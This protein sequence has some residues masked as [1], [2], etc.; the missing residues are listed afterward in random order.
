M[1]ILRSPI[2]CK[3]FLLLGALLG[4]LSIT[5]QENYQFL[6]ILNVRLTERANL[7]PDSIR[8]FGMRPFEISRFSK[9][10][11][12]SFID[13]ASYYY[14]AEYKLKKDHLISIEEGDL[15]LYIDPL[16]YFAYTGDE[17]D[18]SVYSDTTRLTRNTRGIMVQGSITPKLRFFSSFLENQTFFPFYLKTHID[19]VG[20][21]P[22]SGR[23]KAAGSGFDY[24]IAS[25]WLS[26]KP[27][28]WLDITLGNGKNF[29]G[30]GYRSILISDGAF[31]Y[32]YLRFNAWHPNKKLLFSWNHT[33]LQTL[34]RMPRG[35]VPESL[36][37]RKA[38]SYHYLSYCPASWLEIGLFDAAIWQRWD[39]TGTQAL[40]LL[41]F[42]PLPL[43]NAGILG[44]D[45]IQNVSVGAN[46]RLKLNQHLHVYGQVLA[47]DPD[48]NSTAW[49]AGIKLFKVGL[50][51]LDIQLETNRI[52]DGVYMSPHALQDYIHF[53]QP[54][55]HPSGPGTTEYMGEVN[56][57]H[58]RI[59]ACIRYNNIEH[60]LAPVNNFLF[61]RPEFTEE[62]TTTTRTR[63]VNQADFRIAYLFNK[64]SNLK[65]EAAYI[66]RS[67]DIADYRINTAWWSISLQTSIYNEYFDF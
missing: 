57:R 31:N 12:L 11:D 53:N 24:G 39:S 49:Q 34:E 29:I 63:H 3:L 4:Q 47:D 62:N 48:N 65:I 32:P 45:D 1:L 58:Q 60:R 7:S 30:H 5:A 38:M 41:A 27:L 13:S 55:G 64:N 44:M 19:S 52:G 15:K 67:D 21:I 40:P 9:P 50:K 25:S 16:M 17:R 22:G 61:T 56:F 46:L 20:V 54:L 51:G 42:S 36:F 10:N 18:T 14:L 59:F 33:G 2:G 26:W 66:L 8:H 35:E 28:Q 43:I 37:K 6:N 23:P